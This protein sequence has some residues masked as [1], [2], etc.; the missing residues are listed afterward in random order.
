MNISTKE[1]FDHLLE[2]SGFKRSAD[3]QWWWYAQPGGTTKVY[4][5]LP[6]AKMATIVYIPSK[7]EPLQSAIIEAMTAKAQSV[8][9][10][11]PNKLSF[12][13]GETSKLAGCKTSSEVVVS[14]KDGSWLETDGRRWGDWR[15]SLHA[16]LP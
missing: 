5:M 13:F 2:K 4:G 7:P 16:A 10:L 15:L 9:L 8:T 12:G 1:A 3:G 6:H 14:L 11:P